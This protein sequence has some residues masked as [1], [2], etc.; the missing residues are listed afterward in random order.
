MRVAIAALSV[1]SVESSV[2]HGTQSPEL[3]AG[4]QQFGQ[5][6]YPQQPAPQAS[7]VQALDVSAPHDGHFDWPQHAVP[8]DGHSAPQGPSAFIFGFGALA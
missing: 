8:H 2:S 3:Q 6:E 4:A 1:A 5:L 7:Q